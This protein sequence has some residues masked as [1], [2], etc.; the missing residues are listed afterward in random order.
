MFGNPLFFFAVFRRF[1]PFSGVFSPFSGDFSPFSAVAIGAVGV[2]SFLVSAVGE[3]IGETYKTKKYILYII[4]REKCYQKYIHHKDQF[5][6]RPLCRTIYQVFAYSQ[7]SNKPG[8][9]HIV[10]EDFAPY[11]CLFAS[12]E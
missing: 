2:A 8:S 5:Q 10:L 1:S 6:N 4:S 12:K 3:G 9:L 11:P 7:L